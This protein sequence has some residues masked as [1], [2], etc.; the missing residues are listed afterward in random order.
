MFEPT[1]P[2]EWKP[3]PERRELP[4][5]SGIAAFVTNFETEEP[6]KLKPFEPPAER[7]KRMKEKMQKL[8]HEKNDLLANE[9]D[10]HANPKATE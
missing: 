3:K 2:L 8:H 7:K 6:P 5:Y 9:W 1:V 10:P 4:P